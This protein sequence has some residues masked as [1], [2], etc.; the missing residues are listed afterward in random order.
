MNQKHHYIKTSDFD[1]VKDCIQNK[2]Y[3]IQTMVV[4]N[5]ELVYLLHKEDE[6]KSV[7][8]IN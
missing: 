1:V 2:G 5:N 8:S 7:I 6:D 3:E 4:L